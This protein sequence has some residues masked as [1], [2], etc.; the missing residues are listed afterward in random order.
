MKRLILL[1]VMV[2]TSPA[3]VADAARGKT[4]HDFL[5]RPQTWTR[6]ALG[7]AGQEDP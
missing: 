7:A 5:Q 3:D 2:A 1:G 6:S 4:L